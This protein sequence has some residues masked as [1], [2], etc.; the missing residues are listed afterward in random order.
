MSVGNAEAYVRGIAQLWLVDGVARQIR[1]CR[2]GF[3]EVHV[4]IHM[5]LHISMHIS[6]HMSIRTSMQMS[7]H[8]SMH[9]SA[10]MSPGL[11][12]HTAKHIS[13]HS[14][15]HL[16]MLGLSAHT[17]RTLVSLAHIQVQGNFPAKFNILVI[18]LGPHFKSNQLNLLLGVW[19]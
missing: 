5:S 6:M 16:S 1:A 4:S 11:L 2:Q 3:S 10:L 15:R 17:A 19:V 14:A 13:A 9:M 12:I 8:T 7:I 18:H